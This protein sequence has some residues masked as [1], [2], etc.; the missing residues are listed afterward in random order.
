MD[1]STLSSLLDE[2]AVEIRRQEAKWGEQ[3]HDPFLYGAIL[4]E[5]VGEAAQAALDWWIDRKN[6]KLD[7]RRAKW[8]HLREELVQV[9]AVAVAFIGCLDRGT[10]KWG[11]HGG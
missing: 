7:L 10:W 11:G 6:P 2:I 9:A 3:N 8:A 5:E 4:S 1:E